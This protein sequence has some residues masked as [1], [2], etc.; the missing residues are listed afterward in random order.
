MRMPSREQLSECPLCAGQ[1]LENFLISNGERIIR[2][3]N[4]E[5]LFVNP[6]PT[7][8]EIRKLF[9]EE[10]IETEERVAEHFI[11][12]RRDSLQREASIIQ[13]LMPQGGRLLDLGT[14]SG[15]FLGFFAGFSQWQ[16][17]GVEPSRYATV[18]AAKRYS[19]PVHA[20]FLHDQQFPD[21]Y[22][23]VV[24]SLDAFMF[25][26]EPQDDLR[27]I[28]RVLKPGGLLAVEIPGLRFR[29]LK[30]S[31]LVCRLLYGVPARL[32]AGIHLFYYNRKTLGLLMAQHGLHEILTVPEC[33]PL[34]GSWFMR[35][36]NTLYYRLTRSV[37]R[38]TGGA[39]WVPVPKEFLVYRK[40]GP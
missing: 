23:N 36:L 30:N 1:L 29:L 4:C 7:Q 2:C 22:F 11:D 28:S 3:G 20:G 17:E 19:V 40:E 9:A 21:A 31:G 33:S 32:N 34:Y 10:Y 5:L 39:R 12:W 14:A 35:L 13:R 37:Y 24:S 8:A 16:V 26:P 27:E 18:A 15:A 25:H 6:R 38:V